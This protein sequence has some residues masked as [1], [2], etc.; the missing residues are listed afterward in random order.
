[1]LLAHDVVRSVEVAECHHERGSHGT[2]RSWKW[3][4]LI[5]RT[6]RHSFTPE[7]SDDYHFRSFLSVLDQKASNIVGF[8]IE[9]GS[10]FQ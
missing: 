5:H 7:P 1:M 4:R 2:G 6:C 10:F 3:A 8:V 9:A